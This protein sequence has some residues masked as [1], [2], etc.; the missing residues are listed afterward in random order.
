MADEKKNKTVLVTG[1]AGG[2]GIHIVQ[3]LAARGW[4]VH[5]LDRV[6]LAT[7]RRQ[8]LLNEELHVHWWCGAVDG[9]MIAEA[10]EG[11]QAVVHAAGVTSLSANDD[12]LYRANH[13]LSR[14]VFRLAAQRDIEH[15]V[16]ISCASVYG[17]DTAVRTETSPTETYNLFEDSKLDAE[18]T[19]QEMA[20]APGAPPLTILRLGLLYGPG[21]TTMG[22]AMVTMPAILRGI[23]SLL[24]GLSGGPRTNWC[25]V[26]DAAGAVSIV[27]DN[28]EAR[29]RTFNVADE[30]AL[31]FG[32]VLTS[33]IEGYDI[34]LGPSVR[35]PSLALWTLLSPVFDNDWAFE[36]TRDVL[37]LMWR[38]IQREHQLDS[39][40]TP[41]LD[42][43]AIFYVSDD[44]IVVA[45]AIK[46]LGWTP[47]WTD[48]RAGI[49][50]TIRWYQEQ[51]W[52]PRFDLEALAERRD[53]APSA[54]I[55]YDEQLRGPLTGSD[56]GADDG[57][58]VELDLHVTWS[59]LPMP[60][61]RQEA[62]IDGTITLSDRAQAAPLQGTIGLRWMPRMIME[63]EFGF[64]DQEDRAC[65]FSGSRS[66]SPAEPLGSLLKLEGTF[67]DEKGRFIGRTVAKRT[68]GVLSLLTTDKL[69][70]PS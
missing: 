32:E 11:C 1:A 57:P 26:E 34:N 51:R 36:R 7:S 62:T 37:R 38:R 54:R 66:F 67:V 22:A 29:G 4:T 21:C 41:R 68:D 60:P 65:R 10:M 50:D 27:L 24:P 13:D 61:L 47:K 46:E 14:Q 42:R 59:S 55:T 33:I 9:A 63:Y 49:A 45:D 23:S 48:F 16:H 70:E 52:V 40:L 35:V 6:D 58:T 30:T 53:Q 43:D 15:F 5:A 18:I 69:A 44:A 19:L 17:A 64:R 20:D 31:S 28:P 56:D 25:H 8:S 39:P 3:D 12:E 2:L